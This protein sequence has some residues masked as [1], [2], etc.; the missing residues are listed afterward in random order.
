[1]IFNSQVIQLFH[2][3]S[4]YAGLVA[5]QLHLALSNDK[6]ITKIDSPIDHSY[7]RPSHQMKSPAELPLEIRTR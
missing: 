3:K 2:L 4:H 1:M 6:S 7:I 5:I